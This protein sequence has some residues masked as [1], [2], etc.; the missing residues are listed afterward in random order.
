MLFVNSLEARFSTLRSNAWETEVIILLPQ[1][2]SS[3][4]GGLKPEEAEIL[5]RPRQDDL[6]INDSGQA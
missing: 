6:E 3:S 4:P 2:S 5:D 1:S